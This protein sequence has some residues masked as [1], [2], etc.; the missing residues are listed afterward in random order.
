MQGRQFCILERL[1]LSEGRKGDKIPLSCTEDEKGTEMMDTFIDKLAQ[2]RNAQE[3]IKANMTAEAERME[4]LKSKYMFDIK[5]C[6]TYRHA[7]I[8][9]FKLRIIS[10]T[11]AIDIYN[12]ITPFNSLTSPIHMIFI[13]CITVTQVFE[14]IWIRAV[15]NNSVYIYY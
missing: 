15:N 14:C 11:V 4:Q 13:D 1:W 5:K 3:I 9:V 8:Q 7:M 12:T 10:L 6:R 2:K